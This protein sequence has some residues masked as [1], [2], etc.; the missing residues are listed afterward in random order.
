MH[1]ED[2]DSYEAVKHHLLTVNEYDKVI[3]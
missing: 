2:K 3:K 1:F